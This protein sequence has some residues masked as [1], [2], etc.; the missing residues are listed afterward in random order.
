MI[1][2]SFAN[3]FAHLYFIAT[4]PVLQ[5]VED[6]GRKAKCDLFHDHN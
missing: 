6:F 4:T 3:D 2:Q 5:G 1:A